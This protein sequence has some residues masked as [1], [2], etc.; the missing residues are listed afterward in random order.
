MAEADDQRDLR[1]IANFVRRLRRIALHPLVRDDQG[2]L[3]REL[4]QVNHLVTVGGERSRDTV[5]VNLVEEVM[6]ESLAVRL[7]PPTLNDDPASYL[8]CLKALDRVTNARDDQVLRP[9]SKAMRREWV[10]CTDRASV[11]A[12]WTAKVCIRGP[13]APSK[14]ALDTAI[15][16]VP[17]VLN[18]TMHRELFVVDVVGRPQDCSLKTTKNHLGV[19]KFCLDKF[20]DE[21]TV[22][23]TPGKSFGHTE[24]IRL[25]A[26]T[27]NAVQL[28]GDIGCKMHQT[29][30]PAVGQ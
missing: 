8:A 24:V 13:S 15:D 7:R 23:L 29:V 5:Q 17:D 19:N 25:Q 28:V 22:M 30:V 2:E 26:Q 11:R 18:G 16:H 20:S 14:L 3:L 4:M 12:Y 1:R 21:H 9:T 27:F 6:F 10:A